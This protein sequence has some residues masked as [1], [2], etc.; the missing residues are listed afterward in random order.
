MNLPRAGETRQRPP[1]VVRAPAHDQS[2][3]P[4][5]EFTHTGNL[6]E[7]PCPVWVVP[8]KSVQDLN[9]GTRLGPIKDALDGELVQAYSVEVPREPPMT[10]LVAADRPLPTEVVPRRGFVP[11]PGGEPIGEADEDDAARTHRPYHFS[12]HLLGVA[13]VFEDI[14]GVRDVE[15]G[16]KDGESQHIALN[17]ILQ[18]PT[19][20][21]NLRLV[22]NRKSRSPGTTDGVTYVDGFSDGE[23]ARAGELAIARNLRDGVI[24]QKAIERR[25]VVLLVRESLEQ[26]KLIGRYR[27][28]S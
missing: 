5:C 4:G 24:G 12:E 15:C 10:S 16:V 18:L 11:T 1:R 2:E 19:L 22:L 14:R 13:H 27:A 21:D 25:R 3:V 9:V 8:G 26:L 23:Y 28:F 7:R 20:F 6:H 17:A